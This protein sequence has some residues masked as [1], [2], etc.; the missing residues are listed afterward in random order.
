MLV[1][2]G[3]LYLANKVRA[4]RATAVIAAGTAVIWLA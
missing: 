3:G 2:I 1:A 4:T